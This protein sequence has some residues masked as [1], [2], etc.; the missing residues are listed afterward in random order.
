MGQTNDK[1]TLESCVAA[2][3]SW[4]PTLRPTKAFGLALLSLGHQFTYFWG[5]KE[6]ERDRRVSGFR[7]PASGLCWS[8]AGSSRL[9]R[10][11]VKTCRAD[12]TLFAMMPAR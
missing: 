6:I 8:I 11:R 4:T 2:N 9:G 5:K 10:M 12:M 7:L 1:G 3:F